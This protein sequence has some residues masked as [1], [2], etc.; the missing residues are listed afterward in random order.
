MRTLRT[1]TMFL[2][3]ALVLTSCQSKYFTSAKVYIQQGNW[4][5]AKKQLMLE[6]ENNPQN[7]EA[8]AFLA[9]AQ[10]KD[11]EYVKAGESFAKAKELTV[12]EK[13]RQ[14]IEDMQ[15][16][17][18]G[19]HIKR[20]N[21]FFEAKDFEKAADEYKIATQV[22]PEYLA[23][24]HNLAIALI[25]AGNYEDGKV[26]WTE[27]LTHSETGSKEWTQAHNLLAKIALQ[28]SNYTEAIG[29]TD[30]LLAEDPE[31]IE[32]LAFKGG[33]HDA[34]EEH[35]EAL[36]VYEKI[37]MHDSCNVD[38]W[39]NIGILKE[40]L[41]DTPGAEEAF[42]TAVTCAPDDKDAQH[43]LGIMAI[44]MENWAL[45]E[46]AFRKVVELDPAD[47]A[48]W[49]NLAVACLNQDKTKEAQEF[50]EKSTQLQ[51]GTEE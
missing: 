16:A 17:M 10:E 11:G 38:A 50:F 2:V 7:G 1:I 18:A 22:Y 42:L 28:D 43:N 26:A 34:L 20:G 15:L 24:K 21:S 45:A 44:K 46:T 51:A 19:T 49:N 32:L 39:F 37:T 41:D 14:E 31:N 6:I 27:V 13:K 4:A 30:A 36:G 40:K 48:A 5:E 33:C 12:K 25:Q 9:Q 8:Y 3:V 23:A 47:A 29:H 35:A